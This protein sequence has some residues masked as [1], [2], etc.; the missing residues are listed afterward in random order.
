MKKNILKIDFNILNYIMLFI[1]L[2]GALLLSFVPS[3]MTKNSNSAAPSV[4]ATANDFEILHDEYGEYIEFGV[5]PQTYVGDAANE[6][7]NNSSGDYVENQFWSPSLLAAHQSSGGFETL[8]LSIARDYNGQEVVGYSLQYEYDGRE[9]SE[10]SP[11]YSTGESLNYDMELQYFYV[12]PIKWRIISGN[13]Y[14]GGLR[15]VC[16]KV[17]FSGAGLGDASDPNNGLASFSNSLLMQYFLFLSEKVPVVNN[18]D[19][20]M[21]TAEEA[22]MLNDLEGQ[23]DAILPLKVGF[24]TYDDYMALPQQ[25]QALAADSAIA[26]GLGIT[27][28]FNGQPANSVAMFELLNDYQ[29]GNFGGDYSVYLTA[30]NE[31]TSIDDIFNSAAERALGIRPVIE[32]NWEC[33]SALGQ[34]IIDDNPSGITYSWRT[35]QFNISNANGMMYVQN[36]ID[37]YDGTGDALTGGEVFNIVNDIDMSGLTNWKGWGNTVLDNAFTATINGGDHTLYGIETSGGVLISAAL[38]GCTIRDLNIIGYNVETDANG[39]LIANAVNNEGPITIENVSML[40]GDVICSSG[41]SRTHYGALIGQMICNG[42][43]IVDNVLIDGLSVQGAH[44]FG[45]LVAGVIHSNTGVNSD[46]QIEKFTLA[47][48]SVYAQID[49]NII[50]GGGSIG[51]GEPLTISLYD[52]AFFGTILSVESIGYIGYPDLYQSNTVDAAGL[53][54][55]FN[56]SRKI[57]DTVIQ[58]PALPPVGLD[59][60]QGAYIAGFTDSLWM[61]MNGGS[62][63]I[64]KIPRLKNWLLTGDFAETIDVESYLNGIGY[65]A[66]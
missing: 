37:N 17:L 46:W 61:P 62:D 49:A 52:C 64:G 26:Q 40:N 15:L 7:L 39:G 12:E 1:F 44:Y 24:A 16:D 38:G 50:A 27:G 56:F 22:E 65:N 3:N 47:G 13:P 63:H 34:A 18:V 51:P 11:I 35:G 6:E 9:F 55:A 33:P 42:Q 5:W 53:C 10:F 4:A 54:F 60:G 30:D 14:D 32:V 23:Y 48:L 21:F 36:F 58:S 8:L 66:M 19:V 29:T 59:D 41:S 28:A 20:D 43:F 31:L 45:G 2:S 57:G 25:S